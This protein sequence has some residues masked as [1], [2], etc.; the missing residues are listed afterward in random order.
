M[1]IAVGF[2]K[3]NWWVMRC[4]EFF[5]RSKG[6]DH[7]SLIYREPGKPA[8]ILHINKKTTARFVRVAALFKVY[9]PVCTVN[10]GRLPL[11]IEQLQDSIAR[12]T[13]FQLWK[14]VFWFFISRWFSDWKPYGGC[15]LIT[16][17]ILQEAGLEIKTCVKP[18]DLL[19]ELEDGNYII[20][21][22]SWSRKDNRC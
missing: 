12:P 20:S 14:T 7:C 17:K 19:K 15:A 21:R 22:T 16:S 18:I 9:T 1:E 2:F 11:T 4:I 8:Y 10:L 13:K 5:S 3:V 6:Y